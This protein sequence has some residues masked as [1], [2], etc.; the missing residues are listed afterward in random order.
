MQYLFKTVNKISVVSLMFVPWTLRSVLSFPTSFLLSDAIAHLLSSGRSLHLCRGCYLP[1]KL[2]SSSRFMARLHVPHMLAVKC[3][4]QGKE[5]AWPF[6]NLL[7]SFRG[8]EWTWTPWTDDGWA[9]VL[10]KCFMRKAIRW[11]HGC[12]I[13]KW[14]LVFPDPLSVRHLLLHCTPCSFSLYLNREAWVD[15]VAS[16]YGKSCFPSR[17]FP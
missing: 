3:S 13:V 14:A 2:C 8:L 5:P 1:T 9:A 10:P 11:L 4:I 12:R 17:P 16:Q 6:H 7:P 15:L